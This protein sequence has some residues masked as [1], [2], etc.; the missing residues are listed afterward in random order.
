LRPAWAIGSCNACPS[1][2][3]GVS[4]RWENLLHEIAKLERVR[5]LQLPADLFEDLTPHVLRAYYQRIAVE[6]PYE[7]GLNIEKLSYGAT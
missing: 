6:E 1:P 2:R 4:R 5:A 3:S 7:L